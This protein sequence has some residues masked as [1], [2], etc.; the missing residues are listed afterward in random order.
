MYQAL[1]KVQSL[2]HLRVRLDVP[3]S[4]KTTVHQTFP[5]TPQLPT[6]HAPPSQLASAYPIPPGPSQFSNYSA[7]KLKRVKRRVG[8][9]YWAN[10]RAFSGF[11]N[12]HS[13]SLLG[14]SN[15]DC[16][17]EISGGL[18]ASSASLKSLTLS[19]SNELALKAR[20]P[21][22][23]TNVV[24][25]VTDTDGEDDEDLMDGPYPT[26]TSGQQVNEAD[27]RK[28]K[29]AQEGILAKIFDLQAVALQGRKLERSVARPSIGAAS[30]MLEDESMSFVNDFRSMLKTL[31]ETP[32]G[33]LEKESLGR[34]TLGIMKKVAEKYLSAHPKIVKKPVKDPSK[35]T[36]A[37][38]SKFP[39]T[40]KPPSS[41][42]SGLESAGLDWAIQN[43]SA[44]TKQWAPSSIP[45]MGGDYMIE[46]AGVALA[47]DNLLGT[48]KQSSS[49]HPESYMDPYVSDLLYGGV[50]PA[51]SKAHNSHSESVGLGPSL[52]P[53]QH[54]KTKPGKSPYGDLDMVNPSNQEVADAVPEN[55]KDLD[56]NHEMYDFGS[57]DES[58]GLKDSS[59]PLRPPLFPAV[60]LA[61]QDREDSMDIDMEHPD[62]TTIEAGSDQEIIAESDERDTIPRKRAR[63][64]DAEPINTATF[65][66]ST[67]QGKSSSADPDKIAHGNALTASAGKSSDEE[68]RD[69]IRANHGLQLEE[70]SLYLIPL[71]ASILARA[72]DL[73]ILKRLTLLNV[74]PQEPFWLLLAR[75]QNHSSQISFKSIHT[76]NVSLPFLEFL[77]TFEGLDELFILERN[78]KGDADAGSTKTVVNITTIRKVALRKHI[79]S[80]KRLLIRN[81][82][83]E[84]WDLDAHT[85]RF[86]S[87]KA[88]NLIELAISLNMKHFVSFDELVFQFERL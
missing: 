30:K 78:P 8:Y 83:D 48:G 77:K 70:L 55:V 85:I 63:F 25:D 11:K 80:L 16:L 50:S 21:S 36:F 22:T 46:G 3:A 1:H 18:K 4:M 24:D 53:M 37:G 31:L 35:Q 65:Q 49:I 9:N 66:E 41:S 32:P 47:T 68:M 33:I 56:N 15:L 23:S 58:D 17:G 75:L 6:T 43:S 73:N 10:G 52:K 19:L 71:K 2:R 76:D 34:E 20:K 54:S 59:T 29:L 51:L 62:E 26:T 40:S 81:D 12:L 87:G 61:S 57:G 67:E 28:E 60:E 45:S 7:A 5:P 39:M 69:Y 13:L 64:A 86:L 42:Q 79:A 84:T 38:S 27:I 82:N 88:A 14:I 72:L 74:G 44:S